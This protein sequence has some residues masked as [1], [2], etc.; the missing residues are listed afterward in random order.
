MD[1]LPIWAVRIVATVVGLA[2]VLAILCAP[3]IAR[4]I[5]RVPRR[6]VM[7]EPR[8]EQLYCQKVTVLELA[9]R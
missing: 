2:P 3:M 7:P 1:N 9:R 6:E 5:H 4:L 8:P